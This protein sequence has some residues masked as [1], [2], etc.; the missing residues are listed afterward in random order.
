MKNY[1]LKPEE[2][3][4]VALVEYLELLQAQGKVILFT[5]TANETYTTSWRQKH[6]NKA[7]GVRSGIPDYVVVTKDKVLFIEMKRKKGGVVSK[8]QKEWLAHLGGKETVAVVCNGFDEAR[9]FLESV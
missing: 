7:L 8:T 4:C 6:R 2:I 5:H 3:E 9:E 1:L